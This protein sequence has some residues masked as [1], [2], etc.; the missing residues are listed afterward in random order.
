MRMRSMRRDELA[1]RRTGTRLRGHAF[2]VW[3]LFENHEID[4]NT[5]R[6]KAARDINIVGILT[7]RG[8]YDQ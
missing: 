1:Y 2:A 6:V 8:V 4:T 5:R 3:R 7:L